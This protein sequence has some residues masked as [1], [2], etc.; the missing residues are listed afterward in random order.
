MANVKQAYRNLRMNIRNMTAENALAAARRVLSTNETA[1]YHGSLAHYGA[2]RSARPFGDGE[3]FRIAGEYSQRAWWVETPE[4][5]GMRDCGDATEI[6]NARHN[7]WF[8]DDYGNVAKG[9]VYRWGRYYIPAIRDPDNDGPIMILWG[10]RIACAD[11]RE[12]ASEDNGALKQAAGIADGVAERF[13]EE[14]R[15]HDAAFRAGARWGELKAENSEARKKALA[16][17]ADIKSHGDY[18]PAVCQALKEKLSDWL[19]DIRERKNRM[20]ELKSGNLDN[21]WFYPGD[22]RIMA[23]FNEGAE[24]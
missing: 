15:E 11:G 20:A 17:I 13:A 19:D 7:G 3:P 14:Q 18:R 22:E 21:F 12:D 10:A 5:L 16:L 6:I 2:T 23:S 24:Q 8:V 9:A 4:T 1:T